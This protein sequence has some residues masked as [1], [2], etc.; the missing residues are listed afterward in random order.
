MSLD[1]NLHGRLRNTSLPASS[2]LL[3]LFE[4]VINGIHAVEDAGLS[5]E[6][7][8]IVVQIIRDAQAEMEFEAETK[9]PG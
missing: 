1:T 7:G 3:P 2:G 4:A 9:R 8:R 5:S 6:Q